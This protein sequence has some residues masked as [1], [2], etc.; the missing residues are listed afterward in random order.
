MRS[1]KIISKLIIVLFCS[2]FQIAYAQVPANVN[3]LTDKQL[4]QF[5]KQ[6][7]SKGMSEAQV[8]AAALANGYTAQ[9]I[10]TIRERINRL[11]TNTNEIKPGNSKVDNATREQVG[12]VA[13]R[14]PVAVSD[15]QEVGKKS[16]IFG[17]QLFNNKDLTFEPNLRL[18]T[19]RN[20]ILGPDDELKIDITGY[21]YQHYDV[22][23]TP[24]GTVKFEN[25]SPI[26]I[27]G[28]TVEQ[29]KSKIIERLK[30][31]FAGLKNGTLN[32]D[33]TLGNVRSIKVT[34]VGAV[35]NPGTYTVSSLATAF[36]AL[37]LSG[38][39]SVNG[40]FRNIQILRD[41][42]VIKKID[43][44]DFLLKGVLTDNLNLNDQDVILI[45]LFEKKIEIDGEVRRKGVFELKETDTFENLLSYAGGFT[46][47]AYTA[48]INVKRNTSKERQILTFDPQTSLKFQTQNGDHFFVGTILDRFENKVQIHGAVFRPGEFALSDKIKTVKQLIQNAEGLREDAYLDRAILMREQENLD[49]IYIPL[50]LGKIMRGETPDIQLKRE[51][52]LI[53]KSIVELRQEKKVEIIGAVNNPGVFQFAD[54]MT[55]RDLILMSG[56][57]TD[58]A[59]GKRIEVARR[60]YNDE[61][62]DKSVE[63]IKVDISKNLSPTDKGVKL[64]PF[65]KVFIR[66]LPNYEAQQSVQIVG[67]VNYPGTY[68]IENKVERIVD[69]IARS[70]GLREEADINAA[71]FYRNNTLVSVNFSKILKGED[72]ATDLLLENGDRIEIPKERQ[73]ITINGQVLN[74]TS[75]A[76]QPKLTFKDYIAEAG[77][78]TEDA[79]VRKLY[80]QY[81]N[82]STD[83]TRSFLGV[84]SFPKVQKGMTINVPLRTRVRMTSAERI[85]MGTGFVS[86]SA[87]LLTLVRL[88]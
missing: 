40:S 3:N 20:Y 48:T 52:Q 16:E 55:I 63:I 22:K 60:L 62:N 17:S 8:E 69:L 26:Y 30:T 43:L 57:F 56:G 87:V 4:E 47:Q 71:R 70:G 24:E 77:G 79:F 49:P 59:T 65:D 32:V 15:K 81:P 86:L 18:P 88:L 7:E 44:Y 33:V 72:L 84:K 19:P 76:Y 61:S 64:Q 85:A 23:I 12:E 6:A 10:A 50:D 28:N 9:D 27:N 34:I 67:E 25:L 78:F 80:V 74:P 5:L 66:N 31:I 46:E 37:Y 13:E 75:V 41:N 68:T 54:N 1:S 35:K 58:G 83:R 36:N 14:A 2:V 21:A 38:G 11:K 45:P 29:A 73:I 51:D 42:V 82:G 39:P 53:I